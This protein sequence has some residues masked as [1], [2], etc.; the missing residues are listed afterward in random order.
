MTIKCPICGKI[1]K[2]KDTWIDQFE[3]D[4]LSISPGYTSYSVKCDEC[5]YWESN[6]NL[7]EL[8]DKIQRISKQPECNPGMKIVSEYLERTLGKRPEIPDIIKML[9][10]LKGP[11]SL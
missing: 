2:I 3:Y 11:K 7:T 6:E 1:L 10:N 4:F 8:K 9:G 5:G